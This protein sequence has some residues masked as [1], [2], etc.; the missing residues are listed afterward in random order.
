MENSFTNEYNGTLQQMYQ[1]EA[2]VGISFVVDFVVV[3][4]VAVDFV[5]LIFFIVALY[6]CDFKF[7]QVG[8]ATNIQL[9]LEDTGGVFRSK[10][11]GCFF[12]F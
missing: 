5:V 2:E 7:C 6:Q 12:V 3:V 4:F 11:D 9:S 10:L 1:G 8:S